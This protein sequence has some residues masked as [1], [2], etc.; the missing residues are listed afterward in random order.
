M[1][2]LLVQLEIWNEKVDNEEKKI[3]KV[4]MTGLGTGVGK[5]PPA[6]CARQMALA[7]KHFLYARSEEGQRTWAENDY[8]SWDKILDLAEEVSNF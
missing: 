3:N 6:V 7:V 8:I 1:W 5:I 4:L 2:S